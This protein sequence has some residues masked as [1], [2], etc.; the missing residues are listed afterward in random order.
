[1]TV[2]RK[3]GFDMTMD[4]IGGA[5]EGV[6]GALIRSHQAELLAQAA[7]EREIRQG[8]CSDGRPA[9]VRRRFGLALVRV[10]QALAGETPRHAGQGHAVR[11]T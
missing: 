10:G 3:E 4:P 6:R 2:L 11:P 8:Q 9:S 1:M 7:I 5:A